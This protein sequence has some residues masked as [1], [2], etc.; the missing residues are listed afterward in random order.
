M[1]KTIRLNFFFLG[2]LYFSF[3]S[4]FNAQVCFLPRVNYGFGLFNS[5]SNPNGFTIADFNNDGM[6]DLAVTNSGVSA[7]LGTGTGSFVTTSATYTSGYVPSKIVSADFNND[8]NM[9]VVTIASTGTNV[10]V[11]RLSG[12]GSGSFSP[13]VNYTI[14]IGS[15]SLYLNKGDYNGDGKIDLSYLMYSGAATSTLVCLLGNGLGAFPTISSFTFAA[16]AS[17]MCTAD[18]NKDG[19][20]DVAITSSS[21]SILWVKFG[22]TTGALSTTTTYTGLGV[23]AGTFVSLDVNGDGNKDLAIPAVTSIKILLGSATGT[24]APAVTYSTG[25][26]YHITTADYDLDGYDDLA[27]TTNITKIKTFLGSGSGI[28]TPSFDYTGG[29]GELLSPE[30]TSDG[31]PDIIVADNTGNQFSVFKS[32]LQT[33]SVNN[34]TICSGKSFT[35]NPTGANSYSY[36][37]GSAIV[38]PLTNTIYTVTASFLEGCDNF[39]TNTVT[40]IPTP[41]ITLSNGIV[42]T[43]YSHTI[44][45]SGAN[46]YSYSNGNIVSPTVNS[47][48]TVTGTALNGCI[49]SSTMSVIVIPIQTPSICLITLDSIIS[50]NEIYWEKTLYTNVDSFIIHREVSTNIYKR[51]G[52]VSVNAYSMYLDTNRSIGPANGNP[53]FTAY[54]YKIQIRNTCGTYGALSL[55]HQT[56]FVQDQQNG[57]FNWNPYAIESATP[58][59]SNYDLKRYDIVTGIETVVGS[60][61]SN[62]FTDPQYSSFWPTSTKWFVDA[63]GFNCNPTLKV[64][65]QKVKT[66]SNHANDRIVATKLEKLNLLI[67]YNVRVYPNPAKAKITIELG[68][69]YE[70]AIIEL[71]DVL[72][73]SLLSINATESINTII[74]N[75]YLSGIYFL[76]IKQNNKMV[77]VK[78][79]VIE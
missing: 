38:S 40:I 15:G 29:N 56:I 28:L 62:L 46:T 21:S 36:S 42:C 1:T 13:T 37:S 44:I 11:S 8:G 79:V 51:I 60:T 5:M 52:A 19:K 16:Q 53:N 33:F 75:N 50:N 34:G 2:T 59:V 54:K 49:G 70:N 74:T 23:G 24:F 7:Y 61:T 10:I 18:F 76:N 25:G 31:K 6:Q 77:A 22:A 12:T 72:G 67:G 39:N 68:V 32:G 65:A 71:T 66:K 64:A 41:T 73:Q 17:K 4:C 78:K 27:V 14:N 58:P 55:W 3:I 26:V 43:G 48:Y 57:N 9:D 69:G 47:T 45:P 63:V 35:I 20:S 30:L